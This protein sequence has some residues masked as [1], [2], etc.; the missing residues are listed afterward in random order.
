[1]IAAHHHDHAFV[2]AAQAERAVE[3]LRRLARGTT[4]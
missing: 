1:M 2:P 3:V 4:D